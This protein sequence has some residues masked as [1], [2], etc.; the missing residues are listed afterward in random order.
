MLSVYVY[1]KVQGVGD[2]PETG[3][4]VAEVETEDEAHDFVVKEFGYGVMYDVMDMVG[5]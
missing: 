2:I 5:E 4:K 3:V 1:G